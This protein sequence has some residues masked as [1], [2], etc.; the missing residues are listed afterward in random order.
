MTF[1]ERVDP[2]LRAH[3]EGLPA[4]DLGRDIPSLR[5]A[6]RRQQEPLLA[7]L[8]EVP[9]VV[10]V[11]HVVPNDVRVRVR[12]YEAATRTQPSAAMLWIH[13]GGMC[14]GS[15]EGD[16]Q[17]CRLWAARLGCV[18]ASVDYRLAPEHQY[19]AHIDDCYAAL[20]WLAGAADDLGID[21]D[22][23]VIGGA[24]AGGGLAAG[25]AL[26]ARDRG[27]VA[28]SHQMLIF[29]MIDDRAVTTSSQEIEQPGVW[30]RVSNGHGWRAYLGERAGTD[31]V[32][33]YAAPARATVDELRGLPSTYI[34]VGELDPFRDEDIAYASHLLQAGVPC[35]LHVTPGVFHGSEGQVLDAPSS[36]RI[37]RYRNDWLARA[38]G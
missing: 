21:R 33:I 15:V 16:D 8:P 3:V 23:L 10:A 31:D 27:E 36:R 2:E 18:I 32:P 38:L 35:E 11:D 37:R 24:S 19:P 14:F 26:L 25:T 9:G 30:N 5:A 7:A 13:G 1:L 34:D 22:R 28:L 4:M 6:M 17:M 20:R 12:V 29:P